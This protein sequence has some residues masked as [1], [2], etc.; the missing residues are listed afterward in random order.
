MKIVKGLKNIW[1]IFNLKVDI[2]E[3]Q[4]NVNFEKVGIRECRVN[5]DFRK[6]F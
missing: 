5:A 6:A 3:C 1:K 2:L 4:L